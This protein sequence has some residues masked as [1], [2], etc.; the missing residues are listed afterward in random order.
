M[1]Q[2]PHCMSSFFIKP[3]SRHPRNAQMAEAALRLL[4]L[5][6]S[7]HT[8]HSVRNS[9]TWLF[10]IHTLSTIVT[11]DLPLEQS[12]IT[13]KMSGL[14]QWRMTRAAHHFRQPQ[15]NIKHP[16]TARY[17]IAQMTRILPQPKI[18]PPLSA[19]SLVR[20]AMHGRCSPSSEHAVGQRGMRLR[21][22]KLVLL[23]SR[24]YGGCLEN[25]S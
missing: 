21:I 12:F 8:M 6:A 3:P 25:M 13:W 9:P 2:Q 11:G 24:D 4:L 22:S 18:P 7:S 1:A 15:P 17:P 10:T 16:T 5:T 20:I 23:I 19:K 14:G